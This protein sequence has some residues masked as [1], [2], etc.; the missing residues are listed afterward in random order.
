MTV[1]YAGFDATATTKKTCD[2]YVEAF[3][4]YKCQRWFGQFVVADYDISP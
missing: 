2:M 3:K 4:V 1:P